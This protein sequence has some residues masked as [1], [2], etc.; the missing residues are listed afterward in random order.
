MYD[1]RNYHKAQILNS[2]SRRKSRVIISREQ[3]LSKH[4]ETNH[5]DLRE[6]P[7]IQHF[8]QGK[9]RR[10]LEQHEHFKPKCRTQRPPEKTEP[11]I[12]SGNSSK[13]RFHRTAKQLISTATTQQTHNQSQH[14]FDHRHMHAHPYAHTR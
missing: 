13:T 14:I 11:S 5:L 1:F 3:Q 6:L 8:E 10:R 2:S 12:C 9:A 4:E 7:F